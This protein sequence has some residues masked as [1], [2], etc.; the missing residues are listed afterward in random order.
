MGISLRQELRQKQEQR[1]ELKQRL[2][3]ILRQCLPEEFSSYI[4]LEKDEDINLML[5]SVPFLSLHELSHPLY[6][7]GGIVEIPQV[8]EI[9][10]NG[11]N[12]GSYDLSKYYHNATEVGIDKSAM[13]LGPLMK[14]YILL[15]MYESHLALMDRVFRDNFE[16]KKFPVD[17]TFMARLY[18]EIK[19]HG[20]DVDDSKMKLRLD[21]LLGMARSNMPN[22]E[23]FD[24]VV[25]KYAVV[26]KETKI[27]K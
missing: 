3:L 11:T 19:A 21:E 22:L 7:K 15:Q 8:K 25:E 26:Y 9:S 24:E 14:E 1:I 12:N 2:V 18:C 27:L 23:L 16:L 4:N 13:L 6:D 17:F 5:K 10:F 20:A